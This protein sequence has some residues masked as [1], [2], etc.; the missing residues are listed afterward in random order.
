MPKKPEPTLEERFIKCADSPAEAKRVIKA[1]EN[2]LDSEVTE[3]DLLEFCFYDL[4]SIKG[5]GRKSIH[6]I[7]DVV[8]DISKKK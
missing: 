7:A 5:M 6:L 2:F 4:V 8:C 3:A 1:L